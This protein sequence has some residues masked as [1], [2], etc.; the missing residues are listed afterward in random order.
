M[1]RATATADDLEDDVAANGNLDNDVIKYLMGNTAKPKTLL[2][3][4]AGAGKPLKKA[5]VLQPIMV[6]P[7]GVWYLS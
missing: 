7:P 4:I 3:A 1:V 2:Q 5:E 6:T